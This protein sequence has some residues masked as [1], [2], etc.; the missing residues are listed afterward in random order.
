ML[1]DRLTYLAR[2][3]MC[4]RSDKVGYAPYL[5]VFLRELEDK[6]EV[7]KV[8]ERVL[9]AVVIL[10][11]RHIDAEMAEQ[12]LNGKL[13]EITQLYEDFADKF[14]LWEC[15]LAII[16]CAGYSDT[17]LIEN[18][19]SNIIQNELHKAGAYGN[20]KLIHILVKIKGLV[21]I[22]KGSGSCVPLGRFIVMFC[23]LKWFKLCF[24][25]V[26]RLFSTGIGENQC[27]IEG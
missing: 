19:W 21:K 14:E 24:L 3:L 8:Q 22:Y 9:D 10:K 15:K 7:A 5:G 11:G 17:L 4:M 12:L 2:A 6:L 25:C 27:T 26:N 20:D 1:R 13:F 16:N 18:I 23:L